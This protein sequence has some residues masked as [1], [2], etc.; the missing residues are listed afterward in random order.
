MASNLSNGLA[1]LAAAAALA[2]SH[3]WLAAADMAPPA[4]VHFQGCV[5][6]GVEAGCLIVEDGGKIY[7]VTSAKDRLAVGTFASGTGTPG[8][9]SFCMQGT[10]LEAIVLDKTEPPHEPCA[11]GPKVTTH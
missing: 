3:I 1:A 10:P 6:P 5:K 2:A 8:G 11:K 9:V 4:R 7:N